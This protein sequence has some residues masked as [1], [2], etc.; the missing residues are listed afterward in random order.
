MSAGVAVAADEATAGELES[1]YGMWLRS[2]RAGEGGIEFPTREQARAHRWRDE[3][4]ALVADRIET[5][6]VGS[7]GQL[8]D[9]LEQ[10]RDAT[11]AGELIITTITHAHADRV[12]WYELLAGEWIR[13]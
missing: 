10:L 5:Q 1:G 12:R 13:R 2:M 3:D 4:R 8:A 7:A 9:Q 6:L 11:R